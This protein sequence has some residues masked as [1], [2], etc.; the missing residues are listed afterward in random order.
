MEQAPD[1]PE[2][3]Y[4]FDPL[5][6]WCYGMSPVMQRIK[7]DYA[8]RVA[9]SVL[10]GGMVTGERV[11]PIGAAWGYI[12]GALAQVEQAAGVEFG[13]A[14]RALG[15]EGRNI[16][17]S[18]PPCRAITIFRQ[19]DEQDRAINFAHDIQQAHFY[20]GHDLNDPRTYEALVAAYGLD[21]AEF[22][23]RWLLPETAAATQKEFAAV[24]QIGVQGF[25]TIIL[26]VGNQGYLLARGFQPYA[27]F[28]SGLE[29][30]LRQAAEEAEK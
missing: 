19:L 5:C 29:Q 6:G 13:A 10:C 8:G 18:E 3:L 28:A 25:P 9:V 30:A 17:D 20:H 26:R 7:A 4:I 1:L 23:R 14:F 27:P 12:E 16:Q 22:R 15:A 24:A 21:L 11:A 2:I